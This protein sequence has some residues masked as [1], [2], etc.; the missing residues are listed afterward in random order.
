M[1]GWVMRVGELLLSMAA[2]IKRELLAGP[3][4]QA[5][6]TPVA[7][8]L[9][10]GTGANHQATYGSMDA[11]GASTMFD[12]QM[13]CGREVPKQFL[14]RYEGILQT[15]GYAGYDRAGGQQVIHAA[16][17]AHARRKFYEAAKLHPSDAGATHIVASMNGLFA[18]DTGASA[19]KLDHAT[20]HQLRQQEA[21]PLLDGLRNEI[22]AAL[23]D[24]LPA[25]ALGKAC[26][27]TLALWQKL[28][29]FLEHPQ[30]ELSNNVAEN[31][32]RPIA[33]GRKKLDPF[34]QRASTPKDRRHPLRHRLANGSIFPPETISLKC[35]LDWLTCQL[36]KLTNSHLPHGTQ[37]VPFSPQLGWS[38]AY[39]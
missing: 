21:T 12:F 37:L 11:Q 28:A 9:H 29:R 15:D 25:S 32:M 26:N 27:Y 1:D 35:C 23:R 31:S 33:F 6:E 20:R 16:C 22:K 5:D 34:G 14:G 10:A 24:V 38:D 18:I 4:L 17:W 19:Q 36:H 3:C 13:D 39:G 2:A 8:Q 30:L 7:V